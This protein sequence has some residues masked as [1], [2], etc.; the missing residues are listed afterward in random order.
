MMGGVGHAIHSA[1][2]SISDE[3]F[4]VALTD[5][6]YLNFGGDSML[7]QT[8]KLHKQFRCSIIAI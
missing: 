5:D 4:A 8:I 7:G 1:G 3:L 2:P 6:F